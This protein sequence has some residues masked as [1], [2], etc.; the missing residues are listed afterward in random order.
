MRMMIA[1]REPERRP[2]SESIFMK[3]VLLKKVSAIKRMRGSE[4]VV[5]TAF[6]FGRL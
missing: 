4:S 5:S 2:P 6:L 1:V 3:R